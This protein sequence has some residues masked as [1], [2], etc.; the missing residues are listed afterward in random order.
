MTSS[1]SPASA[2]EVNNWNAYKTDE[3]FVWSS[4]IPPVTESDR[5]LAW[6]DTV[7]RAGERHGV[8][9]VVEAVDGEFRHE[10]DGFAGDWL[11]TNAG[12]IEP[13][14]TVP[15]GFLLGRPY[16][17]RPASRLLHATVDGMTEGWFTS[18]ADLAG[19]AGLPPYGRDY[20]PL[21]LDTDY[22]DEHGGDS[23]TISV[24]TA[25][26]IW[27]PHND[28]GHRVHDGPIDNRAVSARNAPRLNAFLT[29]LRA[30]CRA[31]GGD[32]H[33][34]RNSSPGLWE[35]DEEGLVRQPV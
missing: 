34:T 12:R 11:A 24:A 2:P 19:T 16:L 17:Y 1:A 21:S 27:F 6:Q 3:V 26:D 29:E 8:L 35:V 14:G 9:R 23:L 31:L 13:I 7:L 30:A 20:P 32:W 5:I 4:H 18:V 10:R 28:P 33:W 15:A 25:T 22:G